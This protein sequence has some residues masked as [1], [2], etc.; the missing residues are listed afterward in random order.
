MLC[1]LQLLALLAALSAQIALAEP[2]P[3]SV[4]GGSYLNGRP[5]EAKGPPQT[6]YATAV[7]GGKMPTNDWWSSLAWMPYS[8]RQYPHPLAVQAQAS[9]LRIFYPGDNITATKDAIFGFMPANTGD[10][11]VLGHSAQDKFP[12]ARVDGFSDWFVRAKFAAGDNSMTV[13]YGHG[14]PYVFARFTGGGPKLTFAKPPKVWAGDE[15]SA[16]LGVTIGRKHYGIFGPRESTWKGL[17]GATLTCD[18]TKDYCTIALFPDDHAATLKLFQKYAHAHVTDSRIAWRYDTE[19][20]TVTTTFSVTTEAQEGDAQGTLMALYPHQ[21]KH[22]DGEL[23]DLQYNSVRGQMKLIEGESFETQCLFPGMLPS[24]P[25]VGGCDNAVMAKL[26]EPEAA[27]TTPPIR[28]TYWDGKWLGKKATLIPIAE[29]YQQDATA[30]KLREQLRT[31]LEAWFTA[32]NEKGQAKQQQLFWYDDGWGTLIGHPAS[33]GSDIELNDHHFHYG[34]FIR[35]AAEIARDDP[36]WAAKWGGMVE[37]LIRDVASTNRSDSM[38]P[39]LRNFD[40][41]AGHSW[42]SGHGKFGDGNNNES[43]S[44]AMNAWYG[45]ILWGEFTGNREIRDLG[46]FLY[47]TEMNAIHEYWFDVHDAN[48]PDTYTPSVVTMV[49]GGKGANGTWFS[50]N[51]EV[52]HGINWLPIH[53]GSLYLGH[54][55]AYVE[56][57]YAALKRENDNKPWDEWVDLIWMYRALSDP[58]DALRQFDADR[59]SARKE[60]GNS[61]ANTYHWIGSIQRLGRVQ[62][63][64]TADTPLYAVFDAPGKRTY[65]VYSQKA[66]RTVAFSDGFRL[67]V[68]KAGLSTAHRNLD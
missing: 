18:T 47:T 55:P 33:Y 32:T 42:A 35:A 11:V 21:W 24:L 15:T 31:R 28:D 10:D 34:Y 65:V 8:E 19:K 2:A 9:G 3:V 60:G 46:V 5:A 39:F 67:T 68:A 51:P 56:K 52:I 1:R 4:G 25:N 49:W 29:Q 37:M 36:K 16:V 61:L 54:F 57:N 53:G 17:G 7:A 38:F 6:I 27:E 26:L 22:T 62:A 48:H 63:K 59:D 45:M 44:E 43:S 12:D 64:V 40:P 23:L 20:S 41:Y 14:S 58:A 13:T 66:G 50:G 30:D